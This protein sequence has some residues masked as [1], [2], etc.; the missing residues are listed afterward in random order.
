RHLAA[1]DQDRAVVRRQRP[2]QDLDQSRLSGSV[3]A[4]DRDD[5]PGIDLETDAADRPDAPEALVDLS[6]LDERCADRAGH[7]SLRIRSRQVSS[8]RRNWSSSSAAMTRER[9]T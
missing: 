5:L 3:V 8:P 7:R 2:R 6:E 4:H 1:I 9:W